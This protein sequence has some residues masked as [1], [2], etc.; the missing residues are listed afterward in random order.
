MRPARLV[1]LAATFW[2]FWALVA[3]ARHV[4][5]LGHGAPPTT[6][7]D[8][9]RVGSADWR[10]LEE[11]AGWVAAEVPTGGVLV[12]HSEPPD[13]FLAWSF[14]YLLPRHVVL[15]ENHVAGLSAATYA[16]AFRSDRNDAGWRRVLEHPD[17]H[18]LYRRAP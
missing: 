6:Y 15:P 5:R 1:L 3:E 9:W 7:T 14:G 16:V 11:L 2:A 8:R 17:G 10:V 18:H 13:H 12:F 4:W